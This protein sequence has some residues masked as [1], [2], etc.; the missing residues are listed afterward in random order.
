MTATNITDIYIGRWLLPVPG[1][2][3]IKLVLVT[4]T[5]IRKN[6]TGWSLICKQLQRIYVKKRLFLSRGLPCI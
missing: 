6:L 3:T 5:S 4:Y 2:K 1:N